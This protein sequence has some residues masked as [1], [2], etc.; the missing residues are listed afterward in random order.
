MPLPPEM[1]EDIAR[2]IEEQRQAIADLE[3]TVSNLRQAGVDALAAEQELRAARESLRQLEV[4][5]ELE[6][7][8]TGGA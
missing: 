2:T 5:Y 4:F 7:R 3:E 6:R 8:R 1:M